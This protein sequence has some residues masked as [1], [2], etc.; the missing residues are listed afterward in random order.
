MLANEQPDPERGIWPSRPFVPDDLTIL[1]QR[2][3]NGITTI[4]HV[5]DGGGVSALLVSAEVERKLYGGLVTAG[6]KADTESWGLMAA[7]FGEAPLEHGIGGNLG[8]AGHTC[9]AFCGSSVGYVQNIYAV[10]IEYADGTIHR[11]E[12]EADGCT[13]LFAPV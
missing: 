12:Q 2:T 8:G 9:I 6:R 5:I 10:E 4:N 13:I 7:N 1:G 3:W 11:A